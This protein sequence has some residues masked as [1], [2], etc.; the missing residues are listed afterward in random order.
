MTD[1]NTPTPTPAPQLDAPNPFYDM[2]E[3][4]D[5]NN[6][7]DNQWYDTFAA[8]L[9]GARSTKW[10]TTKWIIFAPEKTGGSVARRYDSGE[11][12]EYWRAMLARGSANSGPIPSVE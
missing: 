11:E 7:L 6:N 4:F 5:Q 2:W 12:F 8:A 3:L 10:R 9:Q 1:P